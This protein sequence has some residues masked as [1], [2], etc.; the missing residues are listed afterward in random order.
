MFGSKLQVA[1]LSDSLLC[2]TNSTIGST[3]AVVV[4]LHVIED[5]YIVVQLRSRLRMVT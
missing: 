4:P 1:T 3:E 2:E 5:V